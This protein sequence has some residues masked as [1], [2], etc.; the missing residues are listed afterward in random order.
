MEAMA[1]VVERRI[2][3][4]QVTGSTPVSL[5]KYIDMKEFPKY[6]WHK[7]QYGYD[8]ALK[9]VTVGND[10]TAK[11]WRNAGLYTAKA[12]FVENK[13]MVRILHYD[14]IEYVECTEENW[15]EDN[16]GYLEP[17]YSYDYDPFIK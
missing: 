15:M 4:P 6:I 1:Q 7:T 5:P 11:Y 12:E 3:A 13:L 17:E 10:G 14:P 16:R 2:V 8:N 9:L